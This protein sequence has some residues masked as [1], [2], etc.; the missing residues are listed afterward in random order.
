MSAL[1]L[2]AE[3][4]RLHP[5][6]RDDLLAGLPPEQRAEMIRMIDDVRPAAL[7]APDAFARMIEEMM[8]AAPPGALWRSDTDVL[9]QLLEAESPALRRRLR[10]VF[11]GG[12]ASLLSG[13]VRDLVAD[14]LDRALQQQPPGR[15]APAPRRPRWR[16]WLR[17]LG[18]G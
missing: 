3:L 15:P 17:P 6:Q 14:H 18:L 16:Q 1:E 9:E 12:A 13:H 5:G 8:D 7:R 2:A 10:D 11:A 4:A